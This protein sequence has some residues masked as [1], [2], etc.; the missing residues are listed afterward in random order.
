MTYRVYF[1][2]VEVGQE[3]PPFVRTTDF[4]NWNRYASVNDEFTFTHMDDDYCRAKLGLP[5]AIGMGNLRLA[6]VVNML[7]EWA[8]DE[9]DI[10][11]A[12]IEFR[13][14]N[15]KNDTLRATGRVIDKQTVDG[16]HLVRIATDVLNQHG[17]G[18]AP[19]QA[20][21]VLP[22]RAELR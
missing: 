22:S 7:Q 6:Y 17:A 16:E 15:H 8:G 20:V 10:R 21:V 2:D 14:M 9:T 1:E 5:G 3:L 12:S 11:E 13:G 4:M 19:G 18:T